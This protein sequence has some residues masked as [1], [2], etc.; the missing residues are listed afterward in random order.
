MI[1]S[2]FSRHFEAVPPPLFFFDRN[3]AIYPPTRC[4][5]SRTVVLQPPLFMHHTR[6]SV[7]TGIAAKI[8]EGGFP[9]LYRFIYSI[10]INLYRGLFHAINE[11]SVIKYLSYQIANETQ[12]R[13]QH[14]V[15]ILI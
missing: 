13:T 2:S 10:Y 14:S 7:E 15:H 6:T 11:G 4:E 8:G 5:K 12:R 3:S 1:S 9:K